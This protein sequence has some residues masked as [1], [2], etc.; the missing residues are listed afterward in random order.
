MSVVLLPNLPIRTLDTQCIEIVSL[1]KEEFID[2]LPTIKENFLNHGPADATIRKYYP[3]LPE[4]SR[5]AV[6]E[7]H[8]EDVAY[9]ARV[10]R[11]AY[12]KYCMSLTLDDLEFAEFCQYFYEP[13]SQ[14]VHI[15]ITE[16]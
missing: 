15:W 5:R 8:S 1:T 16:S 7:Y 12:G 2:V 9:I 14:E 11:S 3:G 6:R 13:S 10:K 4:T